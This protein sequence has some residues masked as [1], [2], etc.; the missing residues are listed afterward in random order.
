MVL[1]MNDAVRPGAP[2]HPKMDTA[3]SEPSK[4]IRTLVGGTESVPDSRTECMEVM[5]LAFA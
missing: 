2:N 5:G 1:V 3:T 4:N